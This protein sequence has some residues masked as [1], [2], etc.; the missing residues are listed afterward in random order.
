MIKILTSISVSFIVF[1][2]TIDNSNSFFTISKTFIYR[3]SLCLYGGGVGWGIKFTS[4]PILLYCI[5]RLKTTSFTTQYCILTGGGSQL[6]MII[7]LK[8]NN[9]IFFKFSNQDVS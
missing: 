5:L 6:I 1:I 8:I 7:L 4:F 2:V 3:W 9:G